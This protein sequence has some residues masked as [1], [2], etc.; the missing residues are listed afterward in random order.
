M[1]PTILLLNGPNLNLLGTREPERYGTETLADIEARLSAIAAT[2]G[3]GVRARQS[4]HEGVM[5]DEIHAAYADGVLGV[6]LNAGAL[7]HTSVALRDALLGTSLP[8][9]EVHITNV[10]SR[11]P[12]R[13]V[14][15]LHDVAAGVIVGC[16]T[17]GY[18]LALA[19]LLHR[20]ASSPPRS[21]ALATPGSSR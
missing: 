14:S 11:E 8:F 1:N 7:T 16:G 18:D 17:L 9:I 21:V 3:F 15:L 2:R 19:A 12:F 6:I 4:N 20:V 10:W 5:I 13:Q